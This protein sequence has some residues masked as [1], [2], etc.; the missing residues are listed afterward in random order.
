[1]RAFSFR[2]THI[3]LFILVIIVLSTILFFFFSLPSRS[4][5]M[6]IDE[7]LSQVDSL[8]AIGDYDTAWSS[9]RKIAKTIR[10]S[11]ET[12]GVVRRALILQRDSFAK[13]QLEDALDKY[14]DNLELLAVY[15]H[16][17]LREEEYEKI[18]PYAKNLEATNY[19]SLNSELRFKLDEQTVRIAN[20]KKSEDEQA[21]VIDYYAEDY[22]QAY[23]DIY[24]SIGDPAYLRN[25]ALVYALKGHMAKAFSYH[26][27][28]ITSYE[29]P[30]FWAQI[31]YDAYMFEQVVADLQVFEYSSNELALLAD[32]YVHLGL[33]EEAQQ[34][35]LNS[36]Q[37]FSQ[38]NPIAWH[39]TALYYHSLGD[40]KNANDLILYLVET[41]PNY[42]D[43]LAAYGQF[44][45]TDEPSPSTTVFTSLLEEKG[46]QSIQMKQNEE[47]KHFDVRDVLAK[48]DTAID[49][50]LVSD[51]TRAMELLIERTKLYWSAAEP[52][53][54]SQQKASD[55]WG[56][57][58]N[59]VQDPYGYNSM[60]IRFAMWFFFTQNMIEDA[61]A[62]F[63]THCTNRYAAHYEL[64][65]TY[66][67][68]PIPGMEN[69]EYE[70]GSYIALEQGRY[71]DAQLWLLHL[72]PDNT[73]GP[74]VS[75][76]AAFNLTTLYNATGKRSLALSM[77]ES[78]LN[79]V[80]EDNLKADIY[81]R[82]ALIQSE[83]GDTKKA[84]ISLNEALS[85]D[86]NHSFA[87]LLQKKLTN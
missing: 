13:E 63:A 49:D 48:M 40:A 76:S 77:Y 87:R 34:T 86:S 11:S 75:A 42:V 18:L 80:K 56:M 70:Y 28:V 74:G 17:G 36:T 38:E 81:Y 21:T 20:E 57:L 67:K 2:K 16:M 27:S 5:G 51:E 52:T 84:S 3:A 58:E 12:L 78:F 46:M 50:L 9:L 64:L 79:F 66:T 19:G 82:M 68:T 53:L 41:F 30:L 15:V 62:L 37:E 60:L 31:S 43:G 59:Y 26:P 32:A 72:M 33:L 4:V 7:Q 1:M 69:W 24:N 23:S 39:N 14:P 22:V 85:L 54:T 35:W 8:I 45:V 47:I 61:D 73:I 83:A 10:S 29:N 6:S 25:A 71:D 65:E 44:S 55:V